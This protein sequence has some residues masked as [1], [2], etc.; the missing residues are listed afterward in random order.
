MADVIREPKQKRSIEKK[1]RIIKAGYDLFAEKGYFCTNTAEI[2]KAAG[3]STGIVYGY[4]HDKRDILLEALDIYIHAVFTPILAL[5]DDVTELD[6]EKIIPLAIDRGVQAHR[7]NK[8]MHN[9]LHSLSTQDE[10]VLERFSELEQEV[11][12]TLSKKLV[13][14]GYPSLHL[15]EKVHTAISFVQSFAHEEV[16]DHHDYIDYDEMRRL[17]TVALIDLFR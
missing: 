8:E 1:E 7:D 5:L 14:L 4:F 9:T 10:L 16:Y 15:Y 12:Q 6:F 11:T 17:V 2:A 13:A 3:V